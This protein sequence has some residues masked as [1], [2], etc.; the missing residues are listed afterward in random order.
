VNIERITK[1]AMRAVVNTFQHIN[2]KLNL[3]DNERVEVHI[4][5]IT[6]VI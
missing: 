2:L 6:S 4:M 5:C 1:N 3:I